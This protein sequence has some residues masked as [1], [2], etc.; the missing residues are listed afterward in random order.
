LKRASVWVNWIK[1]GRNI[2][3]RD[4]TRI[5]EAFGLVVDQNKTDPYPVAV[6]QAHALGGRELTAIFAL[7]VGKSAFRDMKKELKQEL[8]AI[9]SE[10]GW[11]LS[12]CIRTFVRNFEGR[13]TPEGE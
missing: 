4:E 7:A 8:P 3:T 11:H 12:P 13:P 6:R 10:K 2:A 5:H 9:L 1:A